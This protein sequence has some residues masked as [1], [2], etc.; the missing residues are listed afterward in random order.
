M[1]DLSSLGGTTDSG[2]NDA[3]NNDTGNNDD[4]G[5]DG[6]ASNSCS[7]THILC[8]NFDDD[9]GW[10]SSVWKEQKQY[11][12]MAVVTDDF[13]SA[14]GSLRITADAAAAHGVLL[15]T[16]PVPVQH[17]TCSV[18]LRISNFKT[19][20]LIDVS[21]VILYDIT[22]PNFVD[23]EILLQGYNGNGSLD[24]LTET[25][26]AAVESAQS[27]NVSVI[28]GAWHQ[29]FVTL[30]LDWP[31]TATMAIDNPGKGIT[32]AITPPASISSISFEIGLPNA[33][34]AGAWTANFDDAVCDP[35]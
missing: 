17:F 14:P 19:G 16:F 12:T 7:G 8:E 9:G 27:L 15:G 5:N 24:L 33:G 18:W 21:P 26:D 3:A 13:R 29:L 4:A 34:T 31:P 1:I 30:H 25:Q 10:D 6:D 2:N 11:A 35:M 22:D 28:D 32:R 20:Y 23:Y